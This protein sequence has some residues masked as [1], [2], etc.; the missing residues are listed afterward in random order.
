MYRTIFFLSLFLLVP[1]SLAASVDESSNLTLEL[2]VGQ[3]EHE[4]GT[5][6]KLQLSLAAEDDTWRLQARVDEVSSPELEKP[7]KDLQLE[8]EHVRIDWPALACEKASLRL[9]DSPWGRQEVDAALDWRSAQDWQ[10]SFSGLKYAGDKVG[11]QV[12]MAGET[13]QLQVKAGA[14]QVQRIVPLRQALRDAGLE[15]ATGVLSADVSA[16]G[17]STGV[18]TLKVAGT[19]RRLAWSDAEGLQAAEN[20]RANYAV[21]SK[22]TDGHWSGNLQ[23]RLN[24]GELYSDPVFL[25][26]KA[27][28]LNLTLRGAYQPASKRLRLDQFSLDAGKVMQANGKLVLDTKRLKLRDAAVQLKLSDLDKTYAVLLQPLLIGTGLDDLEVLGSAEAR[29]ALKAG[30][31]VSA[32]LQARQVDM[33]DLNGGFAGLGIEADVHWRGVGESPASRIDFENVQLGKLDF[34]ASRMRFNTRGTY[35]YLLEPLVIPFYEGRVVVNDLTWLSTES[36]PDAGFSLLVS[37]VSLQAL[38]RAME[39]PEMSGAID[40]EI[41]RARYAGEELRVDGDIEI[42]AFDGRMLLRGLRLQQ[43]TSAAPVL[44][45][46][47]ELRRLD[48]AKLTK[49]FSFG[50]IR[51]R[52]NGEVNDLQLVAWEPNRF[53]ARFYSPEDDDL[54]HKIS[55]RAVEDLTELGNGVPGALASPFLRFFEE[56]SYDRVELKVAQRGDRA[57]IGG[58]PHEN[59]GYYLVKGSGIPRI[60]VIGRNRDVAWSSLLAR[61]KSIRADGIA[62]E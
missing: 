20:L 28:P 18:Q 37:D 15:S 8:C 25:D 27:Q 2:V 5:I 36:G 42:R 7:L 19:A 41:P 33:A 58:I 47:M 35:F 4:Q 62:V 1:Q 30:E 13:W 46:E 6:E 43:L 50:R 29:V 10:L 39:W 24:S 21:K 16:Q 52:L 49:T 3:L 14:L 54:P 31:L 34:G 56:F 38:S 32:D 51:G 60:D 17:D 22:N 59:G 23:L 9:A 55:Q 11:G 61:L 12:A 45:A 57:R 40:G 26:F 44:E 48:L 53:E